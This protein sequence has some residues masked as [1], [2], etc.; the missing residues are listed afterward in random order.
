MRNPSLFQNS[1]RQAVKQTQLHLVFTA[2]TPTAIIQD[3]KSSL[4]LFKSDHK[5]LTG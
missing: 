2:H 5:Y 1:N 3:S 4:Y